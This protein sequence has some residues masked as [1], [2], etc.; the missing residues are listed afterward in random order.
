M[1][2][3]GI[4]IIMMVRNGVV[5]FRSSSSMRSGK[6]G[7]MIMMVRNGEVGHSQ[8][9]GSPLLNSVGSSP[10]LKCNKVQQRTMHLVGFDLTA[11]QY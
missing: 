4:Y 6:V 3:S 10:A 8:I 11:A 5:G 1:M 7:N 2:R 9:H